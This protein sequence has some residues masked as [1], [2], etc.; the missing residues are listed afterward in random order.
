MIICFDCTPETKQQLDSLL[1]DGKYADY[2]EAIKVAI[3]NQSLLHRKVGTDRSIVVH[4]KAQTRGGMG[5]G[6]HQSSQLVGVDYP[7]RKLVEARIPDVF[8]IPSIPADH[9]VAPLPTDD[10]VKG[11][12]RPVEH[13]IFGQY[14]K[15]FPAKASCR[16]IA[17]I[18]STQRNNTELIHLAHGIAADAAELGRYLLHHDLQNGTPRDE[19]LSTAFPTPDPLGDKGRERYANQFVLSVNKSGRLSSLLVDFKFLQLTSGPQPRPMLTAPGWHFASLPN[20]VLDED[21]GIPLERFSIRE[22]DFLID[23]VIAYVPVEKFAYR[24]ILNAI[25]SGNDT[26]DKL[27]VAL[28]EYV[29][30]PSSYTPS[31]LDAQR[32]G[33][34][35]RMAD[36][37]LLVRLRDGVRVTYQLT[38]GGRR[39]LARVKT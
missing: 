29:R 38:E 13:W 20:P 23:H 17:N 37:D 32:S 14:N 25:S 18:L 10:V 9:E 16:A 36:L 39:F 11:H 19:R 27:K 12:G 30:E 7:S 33:A 6:K 24:T 3:A 15:L 22:R 2:S 31:F 28:G 5:T 26:P 4:E 1:V 34:I 21:A 35:S 8:R